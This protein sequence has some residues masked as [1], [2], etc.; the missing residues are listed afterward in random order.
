[1]IRK[2]KFKIL[3]LLMFF[4]QIIYGIEKNKVVLESFEGKQYSDNPRAISEKLF[5]LYPNYKIVWLLKNNKIDEKN[6]YIPKNV[7]QISDTIFNRIKQIATCK[8]YITNETLNDKYYKS[9]KQLYIQTWHGD[10]PFKK[11]LNDSKPVSIS[12][13]KL[14]DICIAGS[15]FGENLY[16]RAFKYNG[17]ILKVGSPRNDKLIQNNINEINRIKESLNIDKQKVLLYAPTFRDNLDERQKVDLNF[18]AILEALKKKYEQ[19]WICLFRAHPCSNG[20]DCIDN[21][22]IIDVTNYPDMADLLLISDFLITDY[23]SSASDFILKNKPIILYQRDSLEYQKNC[24]KVYFDAKEIGYI[25]AEKQD[26]IID[27]IRNKNEEDYLKSCNKV[28]KFFN[29]CETGKSSEII[30]N[31]INEWIEK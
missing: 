29:L 28:K 16:K 2:I 25:V 4:C 26:E 9:K 22:K 7:I 19:E 1:M 12:D 6:S 20:L 15:D 18:N 24:R 14:V 30:C 11:I 10:R 23:S 27:I 3:C 21:N 31:L 13:N 17:K 5:S 8:V